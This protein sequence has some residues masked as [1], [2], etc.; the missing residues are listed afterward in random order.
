MKNKIR[1]IVKKMI[2]TGGVNRIMRVRYFQLLI[3]NFVKDFNLYLKH[4]TVFNQQGLHKIECQL[5]LDYHSVEKGLLF[6]NTKPRFA[7]PRIQNLHPSLAL[8]VIKENVNRSQIR[9]A[10]QVMCEYYELHKKM[11]ID[12]SDYYTLSQYQGYK[13][14][15]GDAYFAHFKGAI[16]YTRDEFYAPV[17]ADFSKFSNSRKSVREYT[18][19]LVPTSL[20]E[21]AITLALNTPSVCNRQACKV[22]L[23]EDKERIDKLLIIQGGLTGYTKNINQV[24]LLTV[25]RNYFYTV[26]E[27]N[28]FY[29]DGGMFLM[30]MLY[31]LHYYKI[32]NCPAN[33]GKLINEE[34][35]L[36]GVVDL[37][38]SEKIICVVPIGIAK[39]EFRVT[40]SQRRELSEVLIRI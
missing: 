8:G 6:R 3:A 15:L 23:L 32:A 34:E 21:Q 31:A 36:T 5:I 27:R 26:G 22:Y 37:P 25:D 19:E 39:N 29:I 20:I 30:N 17:S 13:E 2:G 40:L 33:W 9:V 38:E 12:I 28:Q 16:D 4:S 24:L 1:V 7:Q 11:D 10:Y 18:G 14:I 35:Q